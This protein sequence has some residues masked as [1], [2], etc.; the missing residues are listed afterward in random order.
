MN[1]SIRGWI[2]AALAMFVFVFSAAGQVGNSGSIEGVVKDPSGAAV[3][4]ATVEISYGVSGFVR[5]ATTGADGSFRFTNVPFNP[6]HMT[7]SAQGFAPYT[8][9][10]E[11]RST[12][13]TSVQIALKLGTEATTVNV[14]MAAI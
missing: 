8:R 9:D 14:R 7:V 13:T 5:T 4:G 10:V 2:V 1:F 12:V 6:Y 11:V 3:T